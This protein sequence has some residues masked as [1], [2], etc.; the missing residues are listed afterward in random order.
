MM[1]N[2]EESATLAPEGGA[3]ATPSSAPPSDQPAEAINLVTS[4]RQT[5]EGQ[6]FL[7]EQGR[8]LIRRVKADDESRADWLKAREDELK[9]YAGMPDTLKSGGLAPHD[10]I[11]TR[12]ELQIWSR[13][14]DQLFP[15][16][17]TLMQV[18][19]NGPADEEAAAR[20]EKFMNWQ[21][22]HRVPNW[23]MSHS[24]TVLAYVQSGSAFRERSY[25]PHLRIT[26][27]TH[28]TADDVIVS[29]TR[30]DLDPLMRSVPR[31]TRVLRLFR[32]EIEEKADSGMFD[33]DAAAAIYADDAPSAEASSE[34]ES[35]FH[36]QGI[37]IDGV[38]PPSAIMAKSDDKDLLPR[39]LYRSQTWLKLPGQDRMKPVV[40]TVDRKTGIP[41]SLTIREDDDPFDV[42]R[43]E[44]DMQAWQAEAQ[45]IAAQYQQQVMQH[46]QLVANGVPAEP[47]AQPQPPPEPAPPRKRTLYNMI[48]YRLFPNPAGFYGIG[49]GYLLKNPNLLINKL[50]L[51]FLQSARM[52]NTK[53]GWL[54][55]GAMGKRT[56]PIEIEMGKYHQT[57]LEPEQMVGIKDFNFSPPADGLWKF[58]EKTRE[59]CSTLVADVD[60]MSG[61]AGPT[62]ETRAAA[63]M[64][65]GNAMA[66]VGIIARLYQEPLK[67]EVKL[68]AHDNRTF[69]D[70][71]ETFFLSE[72]TMDGA[73]QGGQETVNRSDFKD[74]FDFTFTADQ[75]MQTQ[76]ERVQTVSGLIQQ[77]GTV[78]AVAQNPAVGGPLYHAMLVELFRAMD[79]PE[80]EKAL[81]PAPQPPSPPPPPSP[82]DQTDENQ[83][84]FNGQ[85]HPVLVDDDDE[86]HLKKIAVLRASPY[87]AS[88]SATGK[89]LLDRHEQAH[90][91]QLYKKHTLLAQ[92]GVHHGVEAGQGMGLRPG[93]PSIPAGNPGAA[94]APAP[95]TPGPVQAGGQP[96]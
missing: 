84:F 93:Q 67:E 95:A 47:P 46:Q 45:N 91:G 81:G 28:L 17:G 52:A 44:R 73:Q 39:V 75:R 33:A 4:L 56:G 6:E 41:L 16:K 66:L 76:P 54:P 50:E 3:P 78:P 32:W 69:M 14:W 51:E 31:V 89:Q 30:Q 58:I 18:Q 22:R 24:Q 11:S 85:D 7:T 63:Q 8:K 86:D 68:L 92:A 53:G 27:F 87:F 83:G 88:L 59:D 77:M 49:V 61:E 13:A 35:G 37:K 26:E 80:F 43:Y 65:Q 5:A 10:P 34:E 74:E 2:D 60:T 40:F 36:E 1:E 96:S 25:N 38:E 90:V 70:D 12:T 62:N 20:R 57:E 19:A 55:N 23:V 72:T 15:A 21:L 29:Y 64:R 9:L 82:M 48:H 79:K 94:P 71:M 42:A